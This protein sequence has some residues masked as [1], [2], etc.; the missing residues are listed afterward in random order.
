MSNSRRDESLYL[1]ALQDLR[2][3]EANESCLIAGAEKDLVGIRQ[4]G[5]VDEAQADAVCPGG[6]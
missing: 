6:H 1:R 4:A 3:I 2:R 5:A